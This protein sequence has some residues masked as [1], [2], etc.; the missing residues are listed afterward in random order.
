MCFQLFILIILLLFIGGKIDRYFGMTNSIF[1]A[2]LPVVG[3][4]A[5]YFKIYLDLF[6]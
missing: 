6:K 1:T 5:Y 2:T 4:I 3:L